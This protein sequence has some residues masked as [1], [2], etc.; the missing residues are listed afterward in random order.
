MRKL[1]RK[2]FGASTAKN[3]QRSI[4]F[5]A[6]TEHS[7]DIVLLAG[8][9]MAL[10]YVSPS[11]EA[12]I[13]WTPEEMLTHQESLLNP[14]DLPQIEAS[15]SRLASGTT[16]DRIS[17]RVRHKE[18]HWVWMEGSAGTIQNS[19]SPGDLV[20]VMRDVSDRKRLEE[21]LGQLAFQDKLT[22]IANR[23]KFDE[24]LDKEWQRCLRNQGHLSLLLLDIDHFKSVN[25]R[26]GHQVG[27]DCLR[28]VARSIEAIVSRPADLVARYGG[29]E[30]AVILPDTDLDGALRIA[31]KLRQS[32][33]A[34]R[35]PNPDNREGNGI[36]TISIGAATA[37][38]RVG[39]RIAMP[40][41][42]LMA[43]DRALYQAKQE[44]RNQV[45]SSM[46]LMPAT[47]GSSPP[48]GA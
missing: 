21:E 1:F 35:L 47:D 6:L 26:Y 17:F 25:D 38:S 43:V 24:I 10:H 4:D 3:T 11:V 40:E 37:Y 15:M 2:L 19:E 30:M 45:A 33:E 48:P 31:E 28:S 13:G 46:L 22:G 16:R 7:S 39:G 44:G 32:V 9:D 23:R 27:D 34:L 14:D 41:G 18:G 36:V 42:L 29:E 8:P 20:I 5:K 12:V